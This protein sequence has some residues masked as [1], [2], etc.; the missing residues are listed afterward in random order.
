MKTLT[1]LNIEV[2]PATLSKYYDN[3]AK[4]H[5][6]WLNVGNNKDKVKAY[7]QKYMAARRQNPVFAREEAM[8]VNVRTYFKPKQENS[9]VCE[10]ALGVNKVK[11]ASMLGLNIEQFHNLIEKKRI[12][13]VLPFNWFRDKPQYQAYMCRWYNIVFED[14]NTKIKRTRGYEPDLTK[15]FN[16]WVILQMD[17]EIAGND[18]VK[19]E[20]LKKQLKSLERQVAKCLT[21]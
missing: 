7:Q 17:I 2:D 10:P 9:K 1:T 5:S 12:C 3:N 4:C 6:E 15:P 20:E 16:K 14:R 13:Y 19:V 18:K 8:R 21:A 11:F